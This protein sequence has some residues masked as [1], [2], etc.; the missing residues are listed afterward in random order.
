MLY[1]SVRYEEQPLKYALLSLLPFLFMWYY[2]ERNRTREG[3]EHTPVAM[4]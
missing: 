4:R 3:S 2:L 1:Q